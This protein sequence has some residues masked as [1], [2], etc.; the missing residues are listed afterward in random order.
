MVAPGG[1]Q[2]IEGIDACIESYREFVCRCTVSRFDAFDH[3]VTERGPAAVVEYSWDMAWTEQ[4]A[5]H[6]A[7]GREVLALARLERGWR[8]VW[9]T[10][11]PA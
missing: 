7:K 5:H 2:R 8:V 11:L 1:K 3:A 9:R 10:Q 6:E 4:G